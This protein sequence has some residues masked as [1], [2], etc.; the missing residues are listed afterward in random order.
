MMSIVERIQ[1]NAAA[2]A[3]NKTY[4][5]LVEAIQNMDDEKAGVVA[6][7]IEPYVDGMPELYK[8]ESIRKLFTTDYVEE[9]RPDD[10]GAVAYRPIDTAQLAELARDYAGEIA[11]AILN[12]N[13][14]KNAVKDMFKA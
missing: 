6:Y 8:T 11:D 12:Y 4:D 13:E 10:N 2:K 1:R 5:E 9:V 7:L 14:A 3:Y